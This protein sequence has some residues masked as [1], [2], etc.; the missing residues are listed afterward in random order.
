MGKKIGFILFGV[1]IALLIIEL[2]LRVYNPFE[3]RVKGDK[4]FLPYNKRMVIKNKDIKKLPKTI[5]HTKNSLGFR[6]DE[7]PGGAMKNKIFSKTFEEYF[8]IIAVGGSTTEC[9]ILPDSKSWPEVLNTLL[10]QDMDKVWVNNAGLV[11]HTTFGHY[12]LMRDF[13]INLKPNMVIFL[14]GLNDLGIDR[15]NPRFDGDLMEGGK[16]RDEDIL[17]NTRSRGL[18]FSTSLC[19]VESV[20]NYSEAVNLFLNLYRNYISLKVVPVPAKASVI[21]PGG[22]DG[23]ELDLLTYA[24]I[25]ID[26]SKKIHTDDRLM[27]YK[28]RIKSLIYISKENG[29]EPVFVTQP[30]LYGKGVDDVSGVNL[31]TIEMYPGSNGYEQLLILERYNDV[32]RQVG[33]E[34]NVFVIDAAH[35]MPH[36]S[37]YYYDFVHYTIEGADKLAQII[38]VEL[39]PYLKNKQFEVSP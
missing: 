29:I 12:I 15:P 19:F 35:K 37:K 39:Y 1:F 9:Y 33:I 25:P 32:L 23:T 17:K 4:I 27:G 31:E 24:H 38:A 10:K 6:G 11:G 34:E 3:F 22:A 26:Y 7:P 2:I 5:I 30:V 8:T 13:V 14:I 21:V 20:A 16:F 18:C 36:S 28:E